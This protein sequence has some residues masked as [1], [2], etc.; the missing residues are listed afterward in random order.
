MPTSN[1]SLRTVEFDPCFA[2]MIPWAETE[3]SKPVWQ[4]AKVKDSSIDWLSFNHEKPGR[5]SEASLL[6]LSTGAWA[7]EHYDD[8]EKARETLLSDLNEL[9]DSDIS[10]GNI[11]RWRYARTK[12]SLGQVYWQD[13]SRCLAAC[14]DWCLGNS[15]EDAFLS[16]SAF[17]EQLIKNTQI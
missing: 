7:R 12:K 10:D 3:E 9:L 14:G 16:A 11:H 2:L 13:S 5:T 4:A 1:D 8:V 6:V 15:V 17:A